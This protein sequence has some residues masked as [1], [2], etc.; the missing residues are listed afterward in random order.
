MEID[1]SM[2]QPIAG[3]VLD[4]AA[5]VPADWSVVPILA[6]DGQGLGVF[7]VSARHASA[8]SRAGGR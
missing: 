8:V 5:A 2:L 7:R 3:H 4:A 1:A 6:G